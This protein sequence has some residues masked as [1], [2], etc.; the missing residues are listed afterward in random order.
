MDKTHIKEQL[1]LIVINE[2]HSIKGAV[3]KQALKSRDIKCFFRTL[4][5]EGCITGIVTSLNSYEQTHAFFDLYYQE[6]ECIRLEHQENLISFV[7]EEYDLKTVLSW[8]AFEKTAKQVA[9]ELNILCGK[10]T[11][12]E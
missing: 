7:G 10:E 1:H 11:S 5:K 2:L 12:N 6:I 4:Q 8:F 9:D 3:A